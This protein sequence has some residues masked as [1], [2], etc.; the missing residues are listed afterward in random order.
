M[1]QMLVSNICPGKEGGIMKNLLKIISLIFVISGLL[2]V[3][4]SRQDTTPKTEGT[5]EKG[6]YGEKAGDTMEKASEAVSDY[7]EK[8]KETVSGYEEK[9]KEAIA[10]Y[11]EQAKEQVYG[12]TKPAEEA[13]GKEV[14][15]M[16][17]KMEETKGTISDYDKKA[18]EAL[19][20]FGK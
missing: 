7:T 8:A 14:E 16:D 18:K 6:M 13:A 5:T 9:S 12:Y 11:G 2:F 1:Y 15:K 4:C 17:D 10:E 20:G 19:G 3:S